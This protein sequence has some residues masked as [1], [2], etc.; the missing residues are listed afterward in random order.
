VK[1]ISYSDGE[2]IQTLLVYE[3]DLEEYRE[4][5]EEDGFQII[6]EDEMV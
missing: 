2:D 3:A 6:K 4:R 1:I 5:L